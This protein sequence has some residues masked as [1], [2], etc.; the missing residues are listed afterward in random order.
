ML[1]L[2]RFVKIILDHVM[3]FDILARVFKDFVAVEL[4]PPEF[5]T[6]H[7]KKFPLPYHCGNSDYA[8]VASFSLCRRRSAW[9]VADFVMMRK[10][11]WLFVNSC[12]CKSDGIFNVM[13]R[14]RKCVT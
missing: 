11:K 5:G 9:K 12:E 13:P 2:Y 4:G 1:L 7:D 10:W 8:S 14:W 6:V 3:H